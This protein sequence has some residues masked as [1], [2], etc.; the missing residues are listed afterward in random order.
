MSLNQV[1]KVIPLSRRTIVDQSSMCLSVNKCAT[2]ST[3]CFC[4]FFLKTFG[5]SS[6][7][8]LKLFRRT[9]SRLTVP[10]PNRK[11]AKLVFHFHAKS[12]EV[13]CASFCSQMFFIS[14]SLCRTLSYVERAFC[15]VDD[16]KYAHHLLTYLLTY[17]LTCLLTC[18]PT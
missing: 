18:L 5:A 11:N 17:L 1:S 3:F 13:S 12:H 10:V 15:S 16:W 6:I 7:H 9:R 4:I 8:M 2:D 14:D